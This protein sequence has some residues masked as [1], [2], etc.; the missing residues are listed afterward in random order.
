MHK[1]Q[2]QITSQIAKALIRCYCHLGGKTV[3]KKLQP[4]IFGQRKDNKICVIDLNMQWH[5]LIVAARAFCS[6]ENPKDVVVVSSKAFGRK[7]VLRFCEATGA[8]PFTGR[9]IPGAFTNQRIAKIREPRL[10]IVSDSYTDKQTV[11]ESSYVNIPCVAFCNTDNDTRFVDVVI[12]MN[13][14][15]LNAIGAGFCVLAR[16]INYMRDGKCLDESLNIDLERYFYR[17]VA[18]LEELAAEQ[19]E[20]KKTEKELYEQRESVDL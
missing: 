19:E 4:Y 10:L 11:E 5:K 7:A 9:F 15:S 8:T 17:N 1:P 13:N 12:P 18:E 3:T 20:D 2:I 6:I 14:R 16:L